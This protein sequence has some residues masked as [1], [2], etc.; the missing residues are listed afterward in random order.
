MF[1]LTTPK[2][3]VIGFFLVALAIA[4]TP[5][6]NIIVSPAL[7]ELDRADFD[8][9]KKSLRGIERAISNFSACRN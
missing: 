9:F 2:A 1:N 6:S 3:I 5:Y 4:S 8:M 7:A